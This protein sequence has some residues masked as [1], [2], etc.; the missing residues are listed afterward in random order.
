MKKIVLYL[1]VIFFF[2]SC[3]SQDNKESRLTL[4]QY[5]RKLNALSEEIV[6]SRDV[7]GSQT[8]LSLNGFFD[9]Y[10]TKIEKFN[11]DLVFEKISAKYVV[12][13]DYLSKLSKVYVDYL[14]NRKEGIRH[15]SDI[16]SKHKEA[17]RHNESYNEYVDKYI[18]SSYSMGSFYM[19]M[20]TKYSKRE[21]DA[22]LEFQYNRLDYLEKLEVLDSLT[23][24]IISISG[25]YNLELENL[26]LIEKV[27]VPINLLDSLNDWV[28][29]SKSAAEYLD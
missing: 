27:V 4:D 1:L 2:A 24:N 8:R 20:A 11:S 17:K 13:R 25:N 19:D 7:E 6:S 16:F 18:E 10:T 23:E 3:E 9:K 5:T 28:F 29:T 26:K 21:L 22:R 15:L 12:K 14:N